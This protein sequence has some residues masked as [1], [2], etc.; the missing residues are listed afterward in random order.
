M[1]LEFFQWLCGI[2]IVLNGSVVGWLVKD[3][4]TKTELIQRVSTL[5]SKVEALVTRVGQVDKDIS[6]IKSSVA[7][8]EES[9]MWIKEILNGGSR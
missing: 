5:E 7:R 3:G 8:I 2:L 4:K 1:G 9:L 6:D